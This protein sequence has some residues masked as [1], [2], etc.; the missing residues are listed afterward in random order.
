[1]PVFILN[2]KHLDCLKLLVEELCQ[3]DQVRI[4]HQL[5]RLLSE[6]DWGNV[7]AEQAERMKDGTAVYA[8]TFPLGASIEGYMSIVTWRK[9]ADVYSI[10]L[11]SNDNLEFSIDRYE[12][13][14]VWNCLHSLLEELE[15]IASDLLPNGFS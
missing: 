10:T 8:F 7:S 6:A 12:N 5:D 2:E 13:G 1:M 14:K 9:G 4:T 11:S 15:T 3:E